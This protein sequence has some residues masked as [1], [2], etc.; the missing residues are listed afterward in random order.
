MNDS[1][2]QHAHMCVCVYDLIRDHFWQNIWPDLSKGTT[3]K[4]SQNSFVYIELVCIHRHC[5]YTKMFLKYFNSSP[6]S[7]IRSQIFWQKWSL[8]AKQVIHTQLTNHSICLYVLILWQCTSKTA[9]KV[10]CLIVKW[11]ITGL[12]FLFIDISSNNSTITN[13][14]FTNRDTTLYLNCSDYL[15][16]R[17]FKNS[18]DSQ[19]CQSSLCSIANL[20][21][22]EASGIYYCQTGTSS[23]RYYVNV[24]IRSKRRT[25]IAVLYLFVIV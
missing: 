21:Y 4:T 20:G 22:V 25:N 10:T 9:K 23:G 1:L 15:N 11:V 12:C 19:V 2:Q 7:Q 18:S 16:G 8:I 13:C 14:T 3:V 17:W 5:M 6:F 24:N